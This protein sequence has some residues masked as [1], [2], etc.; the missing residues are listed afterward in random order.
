MRVARKHEGAARGTGREEAVGE[1]QRGEHPAYA[2]GD[3]ER[4]GAPMTHGHLTQV[5]ADVL[6]D[7]GRECWLAEIA[8]AVDARVHEQVDVARRASRRG[9]RGAGRVVG[10]TSRAVLPAAPTG[11][12]G[13]RVNL[14]AHTAPPSRRS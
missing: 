8:V 4:E 13:D 6:L 2:I 9:E 1:L 7:Q 10:E 3:V 14:R 12:R 5:G 11:D